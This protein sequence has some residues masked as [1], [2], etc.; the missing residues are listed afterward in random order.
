MK[1]IADA[2]IPFVEECFSSIGEVIT[3]GGRGITPD[4]VADADVLLVR[5]ITQVN[6][7]L[8]AG[9]KV[10]F[11]ATA[12]IGFDHVDIG[13]LQRNNIG[14]TSAPGSNANSAAE[15]VIAGLLEV[16]QKYDINL[17]GQSIGIIGV[18]NVGG[19][20]AKKCAA[21]GMRVYLNDPP[22]QRQ[23]SEKKYLPLKDLYDC[24]F[25]TFHTPLT[26]EGIDKTYHLA[27]EGFFKSLKKGCVFVNASRG[28]VVD[29]EALK[30]VI[31]SG[32]L[33]AVVLDVWENEPNIDIE[34]L[35][36][37]DI[38]TPHIAGYSLD[39]KISGMIMI[40]KAVCEYFR[41]S[42]KYN[43]EDFLPEPVVRQLTIEPTD[44][45][46]EMLSDVVRKIYDIREDDNS[47]RRIAD[48]PE[49]KR[50]EYFDGLRKKYHVRRE[51]QN[52]KVLVEDLN[53]TLAKKLKG[54]GFE[55]S[56]K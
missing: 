7:D 13:F 39:G 47:L 22:L 51:F 49:N 26:F 2:N 33:K 8:L 6:A 43:I 52:T 36:M 44:N 50:G 37:V 24:D 10:S 17:E 38:G 9:S 14:F 4:V 27:D 21:L 20:V 12:T 35:E 48:K 25:I 19:R 41:L 45:E 31:R 29:S 18:G 46:Q 28:G 40:Y 32:R 16:S 11:A 53:S 42:P 30:A 1:I 54:I 5:S 3:V 23:T 34:L 15:Y 56:K 55:T